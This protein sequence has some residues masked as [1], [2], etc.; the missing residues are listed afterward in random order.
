MKKLSTPT[1]LV[2]ALLL[3]LQTFAVPQL[4]SLPGANAVI[5]L[6]F[7]GHLVQSSV[8][9]GGLPLHC[10][11]AV[12]TEPQI[13]EAFNRTAE[14]YR[15]F[16]INI[17]TDS[18]VF[19][20][21]P[22]EKR[23]RVI[24]TPTSAWY[25]GVG[26]VAY[27]G[28]FVWGD[29]TPAFVFCDKLGP[30]SP[31]M[32]GECCSHESGHTLGLSHQSK[33]DGSNCS[34]PIET[35]NTGAG[36]GEPSWAPIMGN[37]Y[38][39]NMSN[40]N[41]G[42]TPYGCTSVQDNL[43]IIATQ[44]GFGYRVD[45]YT[46]AFNA[47]TS[48]LS[49]GNF[50]KQGIISTDTDKDAFKLVLTQNANLHLT[51]IPFNVGANYIGANLDLKIE[52][53]NQSGTLIKTYDPAA[54]M[55]VTV[56]T[57]LNAGTYYINV[58]GTGNLNIG[59]YGSLG[60]YTL[61]GTS[62]ALPIHDVSLTGNTNNNKHNIYWNIIADEP[63]KSIEV[64]VSGDGIHFNNLTTVNSSSRNLS[65]QPFQNNVLYYR[66]KVTSVLY[67]VVYSNTLVL[68]NTG[69]TDNIFK[70]STL[71]QNEITVNA[72]AV[73]QYQ[74]NDINGRIIS[75]GKGI[76]GFNHVNISYL[77]K[78]MYILKIISNNQQQ[79]ERIIKQ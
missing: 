7:D 41:N 23:M 33:Y 75:T 21:A 45:D 78:G 72:P 60:S 55:S 47:S 17:T 4:N 71:V 63:I 65:Y 18:L 53:Y 62:G 68:K 30:N 16:D 1:T 49:P 76:S 13:T 31:K 67:Q 5:F 3:T 74:L 9:N 70:V 48:V 36:S 12:M 50:T 69:T 64:E 73:F 39:R 44:N 46:D 58:D 8:W 10:A 52:L 34:T 54:T 35:Y 19:L 32:V 6:D 42:P 79:T 57:L 22:L 38:Y 77:P 24:I 2:L 66:L 40:W 25:P 29:D 20:A 37:S 14:D 27:I 51:A 56:D 11:P 43:S 15:P 61:S 59:E 28:S 26:G